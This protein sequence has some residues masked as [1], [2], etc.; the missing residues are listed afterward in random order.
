MSSWL[1]TAKT[2]AL[3]TGISLGKKALQRSLAKKLVEM[4]GI[5]TKFAQIKALSISEE[6]EIWKESLTE[7]E[8]LPLEVIQTIISHTRPELTKELTFL[9]GEKVL[10]A[11]IGQVHKVRGKSGEL[12]ALK[13]RYPEIEKQLSSDLDLMGLA[14]KLFSMLKEGFSFQEYSNFIQNQLMTEIDYTIEAKAQIEFQK[15]FQTEKKIIIP[16]IQPEYCFKDVLCQSWVD[17]ETFESFCETATTAEQIELSD[18]IARFYFLSF[19]HF[20]IIHTDPNPGNFGVQRNPNGIHLV[21]YDFGSVFHL[22]NSE[23]IS[24]WGLLENQFENKKDD[25]HFLERLGFQLETLKAI[26]E[27][28]PAYLSVL[29]EPFLSQTRFR[30]NNWNRKARCADILG[31]H[32]LQFMISAPARLF[33]IL[34]GFHGLFHWCNQMSGDLWLGNLV[35]ETKLMLA[36][37]LRDTFPNANLEKQVLSQT[38]RMEV[39]RNGVTTV[40]LSL[41]RHSIEQLAALLEPDLREKIEATGTDLKAIQKRAR[42]AGYKPMELFSWKE[43]GKDVRVFLE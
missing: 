21:V 36:N 18:L 26:R 39:K 4:R 28:L 37:E 33:P 11:S 41:P 17:S 16:K 40:S 29:F 42:E 1:R 3:A 34:R 43:E 23:K 12:F 32:K 38:L 5:P 20:G 2:G 10:P 24:L 13:V 14:G 7:I 30:L 35:F 9:E 22:T 15:F 25:F 31:E 27:K 6:A 8:P 19:F